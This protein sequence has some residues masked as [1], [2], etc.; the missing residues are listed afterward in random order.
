LLGV[1]AASHA[2][3]IDFENFDSTSGMSVA[4]EHPGAL[5]LLTGTSEGVSYSISRLQADNATEGGKFDV[6]YDN[7]WSY[8]PLSW[9]NRSLDPFQ[10][11]DETYFKI[12]FS[13]AVTDFSIEAGDYGYDTDTIAL[14][15]Y[16]GDDYTSAFVASSE[17]TY[18]GNLYF[19]E[20]ATAS[21]SASTGFKTVYF[22]GWG[23]DWSGTSYNS[24]YFD[25]INATPVPEPASM[26]A[27][28]LGLAAAARKRRK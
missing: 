8:I 11:V 27:L 25:N 23:D 22:T 5:T 4:G 26:A 13:T 6:M 17:T 24:V 9:G 14:E 16:E 20:I 10:N 2:F 18:E 12:T 19:D 21:V 15:A 28:G 7:D 1:T 3:T